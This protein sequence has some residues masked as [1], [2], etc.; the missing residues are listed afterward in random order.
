MQADLPMHSDPGA[1]TSFKDIANV[2]DVDER[3]GWY[4]AQHAEVEGL[5]DMPGGLRLVPR[6]PDKLMLVQLRT[7]YKFKSDGRKKARCVLGGHRLQ[8]GRDFERTFS[9][10][11]KHTTLHLVL[12]LAAEH[13]FELQ[14][15]YVTQAYPQADWPTDQT[16]YARM[17]EGYSKYDEDGREMVVLKPKCYFPV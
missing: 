8:Q 11:V 7:L 14:G 9:P 4:R 15:R 5:F 10:T 16:V 3:N 12:S 17:P 13:D 6:P 1:P 2:A